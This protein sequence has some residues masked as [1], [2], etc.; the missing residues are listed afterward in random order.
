MKTKY[1]HSAG[2]IKFVGHGNRARCDRVEVIKSEEHWRNLKFVGNRPAQNKNVPANSRDGR[3][4]IIVTSTG[5]DSREF[6]SPYW[7][8]G[9]P[10]SKRQQSTSTPINKRTRLIS[11]QPDVVSSPAASTSF[12]FRTLSTIEVRPSETREAALARHFGVDTRRIVLQLLGDE[13]CVSV[14]EPF[15]IYHDPQSPGYRCPPGFMELY[16]QNLDK[17]DWPALSSNPGAFDL[18]AEHLDKVNWQRLSYNSHP[19]AVAMLAANLHKVKV[20]WSGLSGNPGAMEIPA[21]HPDKINWSALSK[22]NALES[23]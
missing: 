19:G 1:L 8:P 13:W 21:A 15:D 20:N 5:S 2:Q 23:D 6:T 17:V 4:L 3:A 12:T 18:L 22:K 9:S 11:K 7:T 10:M 16:R 14:L